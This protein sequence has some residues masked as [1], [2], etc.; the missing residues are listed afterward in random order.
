[1]VLSSLEF[2]RNYSSGG[3]IAAEACQLNQ[4]WKFHFEHQLFVL[5]PLNVDRF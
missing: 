1:V 2:S 4:L 3:R 5:Q